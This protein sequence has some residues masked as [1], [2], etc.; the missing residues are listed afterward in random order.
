MFLPKKKTSVISPLVFPLEFMKSRY[1]IKNSNISQ[2][3]Q[4]QRISD[5][6]IVN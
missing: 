6:I 2:S 3:S 5:A 1:L 4:D